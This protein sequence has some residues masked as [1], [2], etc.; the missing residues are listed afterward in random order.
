MA[1]YG[2]D[3]GTKNF[4][5][6]NPWGTE[7]GQSWD[8]TFEINL[9]TLLADGDTISIASNAPASGGASGLPLKPVSTAGL[10]ASAASLF[11]GV[12]A[13]SAAT[14]GLAAAG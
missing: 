5:V 1:V 10:M 2:Y 4:E 14:L 6:Y 11:T 8:T 3:P 7:N 12:M 9:K 13:G